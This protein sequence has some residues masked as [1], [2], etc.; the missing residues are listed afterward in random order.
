LQ[1]VN[2]ADEPKTFAGERPDQTLFLAT[3]PDC[4]AHRI[5][6]TGQGGFGNDPPVPHRLEQ[7]VLADDVFAVLNQ[8]DQEV[9]R[10][11]AYRNDLRPPGEFPPVRV[12]R[13]I[14]ESKVHLGAPWRRARVSEMREATV[15]HRRFGQ[16]LIA[17]GVVG[18]WATFHHQRART[19]AAL[20]RISKDKTTVF[21]ARRK[22]FRA[23]SRHCFLIDL[24]EN[25]GEK[26]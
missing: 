7:V 3:V 17:H 6:V 12:E 1:F 15:P 9:E 19:A 25:Q 20:G 22:V 2:V 18:R 11:R 4:L 26:T 8:V 10:L 5:D 21:Q 23:P 24:I 16:P 14:S 13:A